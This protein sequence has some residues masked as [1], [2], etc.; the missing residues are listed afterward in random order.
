MFLLGLEAMLNGISS[1]AVLPYEAVRWQH[2]R[3]TVTALI[4]GF[5]LIFSL[6]YARLNHKETV[7]KWKWVLFPTFIIPIALVTLFGKSLFAGEPVLSSFSSWELRLGWSGYV[8]HLFF[9]VSAVLIMMN[10]E[11][12]LRASVGHMRWQIKY[13]VLGL[14]SIFAIRIYKGS[15]IVLF[16]SLDT[17]LAL[18]SIGVLI[19]ASGLILRSVLRTR[20]L[21]MEFYLSH[22]FLYNSIT[23]LIVG[24]YFIAVAVLAKLVSYLDG[25]TSLHLN[26]F[27][28]FLALL[29]LSIFLLSDRL[30]HKIRSFVA[31]HLKR[32]QFDY[33]REWMKFTE[34][35]STITHAKDLCMTVSRMISNV[36]E[37][38]SVTVWLLDESCYRL[39]P[40]GSTVFSETGTG[41]RISEEGERILLG[42]IRNQ[43]MPADLD[44]PKISWAHHLKQS[45]PESI[46]EARVRY[47]VPLSAGGNLLGVMTLGDKVEYATLSFEEMNLL[48]TIADQTAGSLLNLKLSE[49]LRKAKEMEAFQT[50]STF[51]VHDLKN[52]ASTLSLTMQNLPIHFDNP[53][54]R[55]DAF[56]MIG[57]SVSKI[58]SMCSHLSTLSQKIE[59]N[60][61]D[62]DLNEI[63]SASLNCLNGSNKISLIRNLQPLL[64]TMID[65]NQVQKVLINLLLN[66]KEAVG[67]SGEIRL[68]TELKDGWAILSVSDNGCGM[69][70][71]FIEYSLFHPFKTTKRQGMGIGLF[72]SKMI[73]EAHQGRIEVESEENKGSTFRVFLPLAGM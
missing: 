27:F 24:I 22:T 44:D 59:L 6:T 13:M 64:R 31:I 70:K 46:P 12:T 53:D 26:A 68:A 34:K 71:E 63:V 19:I 10:F 32:P 58:N 41:H 5:W 2:I 33:Q 57:E 55:K 72:Q 20:L 51:V 45:M 48:K 66:A 21:N 61:V 28:I 35:T 29:G 30:R 1:Q 56:R 23:V 37:V 47:C 36:L 8:F 18:I 7:T 54:F 43:E 67:E 25:D 4:P 60:R 52:L 17:G 42:A 15:Q 39:R 38:L 49:D 65:P 3:L 40:M 16:H 11:R 73:V 69:S 9:L 62:T 50:M 14:G